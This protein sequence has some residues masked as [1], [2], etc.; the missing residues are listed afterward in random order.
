MDA[1]ILP[2]DDAKPTRADAVRNRELLLET[3][4]R[5]F[6]ER[7]LADVSM[8]TIADEAGLGKGTLYRHFKNKAELAHGLLDQ[9]MHDLQ[10]RVLRRLNNQG[11]PVKDLRW[12]IAQIARFVDRNSSLLCIAASEGSGVLLD[13]PAHLW[14]RQTIRGLLLRAGTLPD[15]DYV[16]DMIYVML[17]AQTIRFQ[18]R[19]LGY[20]MD[21]I[22]A[23]LDDSVRRL[24]L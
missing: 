15:P 6:N 14:W 9:D 10:G 18:R 24:L 1:N 17:D 7:G 13:V 12:F 3:A 8:T 19:K 16:A 23:G 11:D 4:Q 5:L 2:P 22:L 21:R 20:D